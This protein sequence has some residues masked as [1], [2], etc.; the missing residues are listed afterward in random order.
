MKDGICVCDIYY[1]E[2]EDFKCVEDGS[3]I[4][5]AT[6][7]VES[8]SVAIFSFV[9]TFLFLDPSMFVSFLDAL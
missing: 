3:A 6:N 8:S 7:A 4:F 9:T 2:N 1:V 5:Q